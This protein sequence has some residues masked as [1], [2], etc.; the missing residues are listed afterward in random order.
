[1]TYCY[2]PSGVCPSE[3]QIELTEQDGQL[4]VQSV[5]AK[6]GCSGNLQGISLLISGLSAREVIARLK[7]IGCGFRKTSCPDQ[8]AMALEDYLGREQPDP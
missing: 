8:I 7:G 1:M 2:K 3:F 6:G 5:T 4:I